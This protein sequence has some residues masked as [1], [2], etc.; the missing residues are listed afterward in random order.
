MSRL[1]TRQAAAGNVDGIGVNP[2][3][4]L[5][6]DIV[7]CTY[8]FTVRSLPPLATAL[9]LLVLTLL[10]RFRFSR[11]RSFHLLVLCATPT[12]PVFSRTP[13]VVLFVGEKR[14]SLSASS[15]AFAVPS[16]S[17]VDAQ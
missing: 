1:M 12:R 14:S 10:V 17:Y 16:A 2:F 4:A 8:F 9:A 3:A 7:L 15:V 6:R 13:R 11:S 5:P